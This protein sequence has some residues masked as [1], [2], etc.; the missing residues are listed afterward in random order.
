[1]LVK[2][3]GI[4]LREIKFED[5]NKILTIFSR[6]YGKVHAISR[7]V[8][9]PRSPLL[10]SSQVFA[11]SDYT[12]FKGKSFYHINQGDIID[13]FYDIRKNMNRLLYSSY[14]LELVESSIVEE[15]PNEKL[16]KL[17]IKALSVLSQMNSGFLKFIISFEIKYIS[18]IGYRPCLDKCVLCGNEINEPM[19]FSKRNGGVVC[20]N[21]FSIENFNESID[22]TMLKYLQLLLYTSL[23]DLYNLKIPKDIM[24]N[25][26][27]LMVKYILTCLEKNKFSTLEFIKSIQN[28]GGI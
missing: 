21:C 24:F 9:R 16:F 22:F 4:V 26:Q 27:D 17:L 14:V 20:N 1:M 25:L 6:K 19:R 13:S 3:E 11:Y 18:F 2:S 5:T 15:E 23:D 12:F 8:L 28:N 7:G 10:A